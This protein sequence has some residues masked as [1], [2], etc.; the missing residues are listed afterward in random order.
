MYVN[1][2]NIFME[3]NYTLQNKNIN[4]KSDFFFFTVLQISS[5]SDLE[6]SWILNICVCIQSVATLF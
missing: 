1:I 3:D 2:N 5:M 6:A 4:E